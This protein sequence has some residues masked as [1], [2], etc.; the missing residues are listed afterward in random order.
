MRKEVVVESVAEKKR[1]PPVAGETSQTEE[2]GEDHCR[3]WK[4][5]RDVQIH[6]GGGPLTISI[7]LSACNMK[8]GTDA[9]RAWEDLLKN[10]IL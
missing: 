4:P 3:P 10:T 2:P 8:G 5:G 7:C 9:P 6:T 1:E